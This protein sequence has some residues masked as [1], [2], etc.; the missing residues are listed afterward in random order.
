VNHKLPRYIF[1]FRDGVS[2]SQLRM[3]NE[4]EVPQLSECFANF[5][6]DYCPKMVVVVVQKRINQRI[7]ARTVRR[8]TFTSVG[9]LVSTQITEAQLNGDSQC[10]VVPLTEQN[11]FSD[12]LKRMCDKCGKTRFIRWHPSALSASHQ[13]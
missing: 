9:K 13:V 4:F 6:A 2:D 8:I 1:V 5:G 12:G 11:V 7:F 10:A 3:V